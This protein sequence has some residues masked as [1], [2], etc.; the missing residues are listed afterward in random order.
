MPPSKEV[1]EAEI[2]GLISLVRANEWRR[3]LFTTY[4]L[5]LAFFEAHLLPLLEAVG[6]SDI[7]ILV[8]EHFHTES[9]SE[10]RAR[11]VG[12]AYRL[13]PVA[14]PSGGIFHPKVAYLWGRTSDVL[15]VG[16]GNL[17][18]A[19][20]GHNLECIDF[21]ASDKEPGSFRDIADFFSNLI[22][23]D[24]VQVRETSDLLAQFRD[25]AASW[26]GSAANR[27]RIR[28]SCTRSLARWFSNLSS[29]CNRRDRFER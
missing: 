20:Q 11:S 23:S 14:M 8:D 26:S 15:A 27:P 4:T 7:S 12:R 29:Y 2:D 25:R 6:C 10:R 16:S 9:L 3:A 22:E 28:R 18:Y 19:G 5:S 21:V 1:K 17:T 13:I 24:H